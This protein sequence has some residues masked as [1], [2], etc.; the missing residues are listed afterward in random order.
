MNENTYC[1]Y[2]YCRFLSY[3]NVFNE[4]IYLFEIILSNLIVLGLVF[5]LI[6]KYI[7]FN[8]YF[9]TN[10]RVLYNLI[11]QFSCIVSS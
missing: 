1:E 4:D 2:T 11:I 7:T 6:N 8:L 10:Q 9:I 5:F 3:F